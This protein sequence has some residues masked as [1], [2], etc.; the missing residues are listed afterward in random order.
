ML[1]KLNKLWTTDA[2]TRRAGFLS[3]PE[4]DLQCPGMLL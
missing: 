2:L 1:K 3:D 4:I